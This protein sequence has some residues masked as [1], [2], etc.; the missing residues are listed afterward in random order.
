MA[1][2]LL[3]APVSYLASPQDALAVDTVALVA[4]NGASPQ[5]A[6]AVDQ[7]LLALLLSLH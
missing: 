5:D 4:G 1:S 6:A 7:N 2:A 3:S